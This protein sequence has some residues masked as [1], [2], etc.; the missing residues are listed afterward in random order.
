[1]RNST[2]RMHGRNYTAPPYAILKASPK[3]RHAKILHFLMYTGACRRGLS[4]FRKHTTFESA[5]YACPRQ[6]W[7]GWLSQNT[8]FPVYSWSFGEGFFG[9]SGK[10][11][12]NAMM[13]AAG[14][15]RP[16]WEAV[17]GKDLVHRAINAAWGDD[18]IVDR[19]NAAASKEIWRSRAQVNLNR[20]RDFQSGAH[21]F[22]T[23]GAEFPPRDQPRW[24]AED[25]AL[26]SR[27]YLSG[28]NS[29]VIERKILT[30]MIERA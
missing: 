1:V 3:V 7:A 26:L 10:A 4:F 13:L 12:E 9:A 25:D 17:A 28:F 11:A 5:W 30:Y 18:D 27:A 29:D 6:T 16:M 22:I 15:M 21:L 8:G 14:A 19:I 2:V 23:K 20:L 24:L